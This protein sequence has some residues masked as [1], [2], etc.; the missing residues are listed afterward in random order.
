MNNDSLLHWMLGGALTIILVL[1]GALVYVSSQADTVT[2]ETEIT[3]TAPAVDSVFISDA[4]NGLADDYP[5]GTI[6]PTAGATK[7][8]NIN[9]VVSDANGT[10]DIASVKMAF[11]RSGATNGS[12][13][14][15]DQNDCYPVVGCALSADTSTTQKYNCAITV[16]FWADSTDAGG[17]FAAEDW[18]VY[19]EVEDLAV[20]TGS[21]N[22]VS[23]E[24]GTLLS[25][26]IPASISYGTFGLGST[27]TNANNQEMI[28]TQKGNDQADVEVSG[29]AMTCTDI[30]TIPVGNQEWALTD[31]GHGTGSDLTGIAA[32][33]NLAVG[34]RD[35]DLTDVTKTLYWNIEVPAT[36]VKGTCS[37]TNTV[38]V[39]AS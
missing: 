31:I 18:Q 39:I 37:G 36:G 25:V 27:T 8:L 22:A 7:T 24:M 10:A 13:C 17:R 35:E 32:D 38:S 30:G 19:V 6:T 14:T 5:G 4:T 9:G 15:A 11:Y 21:N 28:I 34:Y 12:A 16:Q 23:K 33:T 20:T 1:V 2:T 29:T 3:N 26:N